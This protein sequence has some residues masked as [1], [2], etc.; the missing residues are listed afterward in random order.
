MVVLEPAMNILIIE[1]DRTAAMQLADALCPCRFDSTIA[2]SGK[3]GLD[4]AFSETYDLI[5]LTWL[6]PDISGI[7][8]CKLLRE[9][10]NDT[11][12]L[13]LTTKNSAADIV[14][15]LDAGADAYLSKPFQMSVLLAIVRALL[16]RGDLIKPRPVLRWG[17]L[18]LNLI[19]SNVTI[20]DV[21]LSLTTQEYQLLELLLSYPKQVFS[22]TNIIEKLWDIDQFPAEGT[23]TNL[24][25]NVRKKVQN[26][27]GDP[28]M[29]E[30]VVGIGYRLKAPP[31]SGLPER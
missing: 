27:G 11:L 8:I 30:T 1:S 2:P 15:G 6:L 25:K 19:A 17:D 20:G 10:G 18:S 16:R 12:L 3:K 29:I 7:E 14:S 28:T 9:Q 24:V 21:V 31:L 22:R 4:L 13:M 23:V 26:G 5:I